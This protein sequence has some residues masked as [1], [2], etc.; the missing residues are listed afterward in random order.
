[1]AFDED[2]RFVSMS[3]SCLQILNLSEEFLTEEAMF[4]DVFGIEVKSINDEKTIVKYGQLMKQKNMA[5]TVKFANGDDG[6][7]KTFNIYKK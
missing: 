7:D 6:T 3:A 4:D 1:M 5:S 2:L